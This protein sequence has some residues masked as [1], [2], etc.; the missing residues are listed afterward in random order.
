MK[1]KIRKEKGFYIFVQIALFFLM[2]EKLY[3]SSYI[4]G[5]YNVQVTSLV[6]LLSIAFVLLRKCRLAKSDLIPIMVIFFIVVYGFSRETIRYGMVFFSLLVWNKI[7]IKNVDRLHQ[8]LVVIAIILSVIDI[9]RGYERISGYSAGSPTLFSCGLA[10]SF[11]Y[12][13]FKKEKKKWEYIFPVVILILTIKSES[14]STLIFL[15]VLIIYKICINIVKKFGWKSTLTKIVIAISVIAVA[16]FII[17]NLND[18]LGVIGRSNRDASTSTR[19]GIYQAFWKIFTESPKA[20]LIGLGGGYTQRYIQ[21]YWGATSYMP[22]HQDILM[23]AVEYG[24]VGVVLMIRFLLKQYRLNFI[25]IAFL[26]FASFH[27][28]LL[29][30]MTLL[31][32]VITSNALNEQY[33]DYKALW[34]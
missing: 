23:L 21:A 31:L 8:A 15:V 13:L 27:N 17:L 26:V 11:I 34:R 28:I 24:I 14:S 29:S 3:N 30:P 5:K 4:C 12:F 1:I 33:N 18:L 7:K 9:T 16:A 6:L 2:C 22:L 19:L 20:I 25:M 32:F 10:V